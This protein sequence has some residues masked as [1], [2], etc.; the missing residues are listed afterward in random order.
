LAARRG[1][2]V[3]ATAADGVPAGR[4][5]HQNRYAATGGDD[6]FGGWSFRS[7]TS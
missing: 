2:L 7:P 4:S 6:A 3:A 5:Q 1:D